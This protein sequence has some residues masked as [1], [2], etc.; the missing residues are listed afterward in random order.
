[1]NNNRDGAGELQ[2]FRHASESS[3]D[4]G[5]CRP[6]SSAPSAVIDPSRPLPSQGCQLQVPGARIKFVYIYL[7]RHLSNFAYLI[8]LDVHYTQMKVR[9]WR[10][11]PVVKK[12]TTDAV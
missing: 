2:C 6:L 4:S 8:C 7:Q 5:R 1:M 12:I 9:Y 11:N 3:I 10:M